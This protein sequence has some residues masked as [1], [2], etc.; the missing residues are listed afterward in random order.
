MA[1]RY[2]VGIGSN[3]YGTYRVLFRSD[4][5][6]NPVTHRQYTQ[7]I[8]PFQ[9]KRGAEYLRTH[10]PATGLTVS[11]AEYRAKRALTHV[12][13]DQCAMV[14]INGVACHETGCANMGAR[15]D[16][17]IAGWVK[18][19]V[20]RDCGCKVDVGAQCCAQEE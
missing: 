8:G 1:K 11:E 9:T 13:C 6:P 19:Y 10:T 20:C 16:T 5:A 3:T 12:S 2:Y 7:V 14:S 17:D 4:A 15:W 18:Q